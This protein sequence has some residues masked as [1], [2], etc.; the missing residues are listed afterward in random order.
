MNINE[1]LELTHE[2]IVIAD[3]PPMTELS[4][5]IVCVDGFELSVQASNTHYCSPRTISGSYS[6]V[7]VGYPSESIPEFD[8]FDSD[9][10]YGWVPVEIV[11]AVLEQHGGIANGVEV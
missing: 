7:E 9:G 4:P 2:E 8:E 10:V 6:R 1:Y 5:W 3:L 11:D